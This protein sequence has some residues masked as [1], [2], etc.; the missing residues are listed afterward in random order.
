M[1]HRRAYTPRLL[2]TLVPTTLS[3][4]TIVFILNPGPIV[5][6]IFGAVA[7]HITTRLRWIIW[8]R[9]HPIITT[10]ERLND[11]RRAAPWN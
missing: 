3:V 8:R 4:A 1:T 6:L 9:R 7:G 5:A 10:E 11:L 2:P